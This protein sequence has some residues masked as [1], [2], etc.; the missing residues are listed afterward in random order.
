M[1]AEV[2]DV[3]SDAEP[4]PARIGGFA[5]PFGVF[6]TTGAY[7]GGVGDLALMVTG[8]GFAACNFFLI[9]LIDQLPSIS[10][11]TLTLEA[12][13]AVAILSFLLLIR[14]SPLAGFHAAEHQT[15]HALEQR[16][17]LSLDCVRHQPRAHPR[18]G[19]NIMAL[20][21]VLQLVVMTLADLAAWDLPLV[22]VLSLGIA[23]PLHRR[24]GF[25][26]QQ[27]VTTKPA[28]NRQL[29]SAITAARELIADWRTG[30]RVSRWRRLWHS[31]LPQVFLGAALA[32]TLLA[33]IF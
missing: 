33:G 8:A 25:V 32:M 21:V 16:L 4:R 17:P 12:R 30:R 26:V 31:G 15:V 7:R 11:V 10:G 13:D 27:L 20:L 3:L 18:C 9:I 29:H 2:R 23:L 22:L 24:V 19:T 5:T 14:L 6:L 1:G 28:D